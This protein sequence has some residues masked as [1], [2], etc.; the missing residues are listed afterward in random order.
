MNRGRNAM[1]QDL[2]ELMSGLKRIAPVGSEGSINMNMSFR[3]VDAYIKAFFTPYDGLLHWAQVHP[4]YNKGQ[5]IRLVTLM[6]NSL[7]WKKKELK[8]LQLEIEQHLSEI[9]T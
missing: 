7:G 8:D 5:I 1:A 9:E 3:I 4:E 6:G 2:I